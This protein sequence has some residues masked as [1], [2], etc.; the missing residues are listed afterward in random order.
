MKVVY[1][2]LAAIARYRRSRMLADRPPQSPWGEG[3]SPAGEHGA[4]WPGRGD[5]C[6]WLSAGR[7]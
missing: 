4:G 6:R 7:R 2:R 3:Q 1:P 5:S